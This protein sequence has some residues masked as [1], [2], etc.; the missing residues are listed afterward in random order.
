LTQTPKGSILAVSISHAL[1]DGFSYFHFLSSGAR[2]CRGEQIITPSLER[3]VLRSGLS[4]DAREIS[5][6]EV[7]DRCGLFYGPGR[8]SVPTGRGKHE[9]FFISDETIGSFLQETRHEHG[10]SLTDN[11]VITAHLWKNYAPLWN[12]DT[13]TLDSYITCPVDFRRILGGFPKNYFGCALCFAVASIAANRLADAS[14]GELALLVKNAVSRI[15][16][17]Y[18]AT[19]LS[20]LEDLR[21][22]NGL[23]AL[24]RVHLRHIHH[25]MIVTNLTRMPIRD[26]E[27]GFGAPADFSVYS[28]V[29]GSAAILPADGG[30]EVLVVHPLDGN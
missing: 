6:K 27:F 23:A 15:R 30:V 21:R 17:E 9:R 8:R 3:E 28:E 26:L 25:G 22:Q 14:V 7:F 1:V 10:S 2:I 5:S 12:R 24:E 11:D 4:H 18:I 29:L 20:T 16:S 19:S 13:G